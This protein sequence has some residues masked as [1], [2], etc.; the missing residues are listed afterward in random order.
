MR[1]ICRRWGLRSSESIL[2]SKHFVKSCKHPSL[3]KHVH[4]C[5]LVLVVDT[6]D[7]IDKNYKRFLYIFFFLYFCNIISAILFFSFQLTKMF[8]LTWFQFW[9]RATRRSVFWVQVQYS[10]SFGSVYGLHHLPREISG[11]VHQLVSDCLLLETQRL[12]QTGN[13]LQNQN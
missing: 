7:Q 11:C 12:N 6:L 4:R 1:D 5:L 2:Q 3:N 9:Y 8:F 13:V 10:L